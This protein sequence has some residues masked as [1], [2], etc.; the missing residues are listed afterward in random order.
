MKV[1]CICFFEEKDTGMYNYGNLLY[2]GYRKIN[3]ENTYLFLPFPNGNYWL[4]SL[5]ILLFPSRFIRRYFNIFS[6]YDV[7]H[8]VNSPIFSYSLMHFLSR[9]YPSKY[10]IQTLHDPIPHIEHSFKKK[11][12]RYLYTFTNKKLLSYNS[13]RAYIHVHSES[14]LRKISFNHDQVIFASH[15]IPLLNF[16]NNLKQYDSEAIEN[17]KLS[18]TLIGRLNYYKGIDILI[19]T[20]KSI[21]IHYPNNQFK[22]QIIG[23][24]NVGDISCQDNIYVDNSFLSKQD[25]Y[26]YINNSDVIVLPYREATASGVICDALCF[27]KFVICSD[28]GVLKDYVDDGITGIVLDDLSVEALKCAILSI[29]KIINTDGVSKIKNKARSF[30]VVNICNLIL[31]QLR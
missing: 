28:R 10:I 5:L 19:E 31:S 6:K 3:P 14:L 1:L 12:L 11:L 13:S 22:F 4:Y 9:K 7:L 21:N 24:G 17:N 25:Y 29:N 2:D 26:N 20:I 16:Q 18:I 8:I 23:S 15:P 27:G 30:N